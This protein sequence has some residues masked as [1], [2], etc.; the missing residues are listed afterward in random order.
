VALGVENDPFGAP[1]SIPLYL[2][3]PP[4][5]GAAGG[6]L[7]QRHYSWDYYANQEEKNGPQDLKKQRDSPSRRSLRETLQQT[8]KVTLRTRVKVAQTQDELLKILTQDST[9]ST[10]GT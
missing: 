8:V 7:L 9:P 6:D 4:V 5:W 2:C 1:G 10:G 3:L